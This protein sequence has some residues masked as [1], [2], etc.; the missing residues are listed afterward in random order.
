MIDRETKERF[1]N[2][3]DRKSSHDCWEWQGFRRHE[4]GGF[5]FQKK[6]KYAH[7]FAWEL[8]N[9]E[10][11]LKMIVCHT[12]DNTL[13]VNPKHLFLGTDLDNARDRSEKGRTPAGIK[14]GMAKLT[15]KDVKEIRK[16]YAIG[17]Y[18]QIELGKT[19]RVS[20]NCI[21]Y[22]VRKETWKHI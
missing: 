3:V 22:I 18:T 15:E 9:G 14:S 16:L 12:C 17:E 8:E 20:Q 19:Y 6:K 5:V 2:K 11:P 4:Y 21:G 7:R 1:W 13:C 10:I